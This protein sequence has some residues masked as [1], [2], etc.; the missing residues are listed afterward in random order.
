MLGRRHLHAGRM[1]I[2]PHTLVSE[3]TT[4]HVAIVG[5]SGAGESTLLGLHCTVLAVRG[6]VLTSASFLV[7]ASPCPLA[8]RTYTPLPGP[9]RAPQQK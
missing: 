3:A 8:W 2:A 5:A 1:P 6:V 9:N 7:P 4:D